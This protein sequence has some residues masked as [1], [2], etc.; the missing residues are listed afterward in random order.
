MML[1]LNC[2]DCIRMSD[3]PQEAIDRVRQCI[4]RHWTLGM[5]AQDDCMA[6]QN[7]FEFK[8]HGSPWNCEGVEAINA[9]LLLTVIM[10]E[11]LSLG[12]A[13]HTSLDVTRR[14]NDKAVFVF[15]SCPPIALPHFCLSPNGTNKIRLINAPADIIDVTISVIK[16]NWPQGIQAKG[17]F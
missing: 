7:Y 5:Q 10:K 12:W 8:L 6:S 16:A 1:S 11:L 9:R 4:V 3:A 13:V 17:S 15:R 2:D 14:P